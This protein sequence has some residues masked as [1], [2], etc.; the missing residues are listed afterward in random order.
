MSKIT[1]AWVE[2][3]VDA[4]IGAHVHAWEGAKAL[5]QQRPL[6]TFPFITISREFGCEALP[7]A[8]HL[9]QVLNERNRSAYPWVA[10]DR[11]VIDRVAEELH[12]SREIVESVDG[13]RRTEMCELFDA[14]LNRKVDES[15]VIRR[16]CQV[17]R[18]LAMHGHVVLVGRGSY[19]VTQDLKTGLHVRLVAP[20][21]WRIH[22]VADIQRLGYRD[23][24]KVVDQFEKE[25][26]RFVQ[27][28]FVRDPHIVHYHDVVIDNSRFNLT[29]IANIICTA[30]TSRFG[31][32]LAT[33]EGRVSPGMN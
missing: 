27:M 12:L 13:H 14:I 32:T 17:V 33:D 31:E 9:V 20:R 18:S 23:A 7:L 2:A 22:R 24:E 16:I 6:K 1:H 15:L 10:Y 19:L 29:Q 26:E 30:L 4:R 8:Q 11:E 25:R 5:G 28:F 3:N 21:P